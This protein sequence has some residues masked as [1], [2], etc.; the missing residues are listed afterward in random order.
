MGVANSKIEEEK[1]LVLCRERKRFVRHAIDERCLLADSHFSY[2]QSLRTTGIE[3]RKFVE[4]EFPAESSIYTPTAAA[5]PELLALTEKSV[6]H[7]SNSSPSISQRL[8]TTKSFSP[9]PSPSSSG[10]IQI[11]HMKSGITSDLAVK[12]KL[13]TSLT[14]TLESSIDTPKHIVL[15]LDETSSFEYPP[16]PPAAQPWDYFGLFHPTDSQLSYKS[17]GGLN[18]GFDNADEIRHLKEEEDILEEDGDRASTNEKN[19]LES[20]DDFDQPTKEP[21]VQIYKNRNVILE[22]QLR[23]EFPV[24]QPTKDIVSKANHQDGD[25]VKHTNGISE[26]YETPETTPTKAAPHVAVF[27]INGK[28]TKSEPETNHE[29]RD[30]V[31]CI[32][33]IE[34]LFL[35]ASESGT[36]VPRMLEANKM[37][38]RPLVPKERAYKSKASVFLTTCFTC[39]T[40]EAPHRPIAAENDMKYITWPR[41]MSSLSSSSRKFV[42]PTVSNDIDELGSNIFHSYMNS[43]S[44]ASTLDRLY[45]WER[46]L[47]DEVKA[48]GV[49]RREYDMKC[50]LL[51]HKESVEDNPIKIDKIRSSVK[52]LHS[53]IRVAIQRIDS[54]SKKIEEIR[55]KELQPQLEELIGGLIRMWRMMLDYHGRQYDILLLATNNGT[56]KISVRSE[57]QH[58]AMILVHEW[59][60]LSSNFSQWMA[61]H[62]SYLTAINGWLRQCIDYSLKH[63]R[64]ARNRRQQ[65]S[66]T[67]YIPPPIFVTCKNWLLLLP[68]LPVKEVVSSIKDL[69]NVISHF[70]PSQESHGTSKSSFSLPHKA[71]QN[72]FRENNHSNPSSVD[73][74]LNYDQL[75]SALTI[76]LDR[77]KTFAELSV[78]KYEELQTSVKL[79]RDNYESSQFRS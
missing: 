70:L 32:K 3:L 11:N 1:A 18:H 57:P 23:S 28:T 34:E 66:P 14:V 53:R 16:T 40:E 65:F 36:E 78:T 26:T 79:A 46:K 38:F 50:K 41:S 25:N 55:D 69:V 56:T 19:D 73:W 48:S 22:Q 33:E 24:I 17:G 64:S 29:T 13:P 77:L 7:F 52:D 5:T 59:N 43:G 54:I 20:E 39:C 51:R 31:T 75:Q 15:E 58:H 62:K 49:I 47:Y 6:S 76:F 68:D 42:G 8:E 10:R 37:Q 74:N 35:K 44:H 4:P 12:A 21:L 9:V 72:R 63:S 71:V 30:F 61:A 45:A 2:V 67:R 27:P 60:S